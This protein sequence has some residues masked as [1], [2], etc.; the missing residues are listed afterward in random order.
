MRKIIPFLI[1][2]VTCSLAYPLCNSFAQG[3][4][5]TYQGRLNDASNPAQGF[6][7]LRFTVF[8]SSAGGS[9]VAGPQTNSA[10]TI[11]NGLFTVALNFGGGVFNGDSRWLE[12][13][14]RTN[15]TGAFT[16]LNQR[17]AMTAAPYAITATEATSGNIA[18]LSVSNTTVAATGVPIVTSGFITGATVTRGGSGYLTPPTVTVNDATGSGAVI[19]AAISDG[20]V[21]SLT[22]NSAGNG[23]YTSNATLTIGAPPSNAY[24]V[25]A[26]TNYFPGVN[27]LTNPNNVFAGNGAGLTNLSAWRLTGNAGTTPG[28]NFIGTTDNQ[29]LEFQANGQRILRLEPTANISPNV[30]GGI[31]FNGVDPGVVGATIGGGGTIVGPGLGPNRIGENLATIGGGSQNTNNGRF[32]TI[33]GGGANKIRTDSFSFAT[34]GGGDGNDI[35]SGA[36]ESFIGGGGGNVIMTNALA[37]VIGGGTANTVGVNADYGI[38]VG[39]QGNTMG[40]NAFYCTIGGGQNNAVA[41]NSTAA[42]IPGGQNNAATNYAF[43]AGRRAKANHDGTFVWADSQNADF[44]SSGPNQFLIRAA[45][46]VVINGTNPATALHVRDT[47]DTEVSIESTDAGG[48]RWTLQ[49]SRVTGTA[50]DA[51]FQIVDRTVGSSR[52]FIGTNGFVGIGTSGPTNRLHV[53]G[54]V[55]ATVFVTTSDRNAKQNFAPVSPTQVLEKVTSLP[56]QTWSFKEMPNVPHMGPTA[57]DFHAAFGLGGSDTTIATVDPDGVA[58]AAIQGLNELLKQKDRKIS[59]LEERL[60]KLEKAVSALSDAGADRVLSD[61]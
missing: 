30:I 24:Q 11:S 8:D 56:I 35:R 47:S 4:A 59:Q 9:A 57:Q 44:A 48:H 39:G 54:G 10:V 34:I 2:I 42:M 45:S 25:F 58:L 31:A 3:T 13:A 26:S 41:A 23:L 60:G 36:Q 29:P 21:I 51:S 6:Y 32:A 1:T 7:D 12:I 18:R 55:S 5:F 16:T 27:T 17:Q 20:A 50:T 15:N 28:V 49:S 40:T 33:G 19:I 38:I 22:V 43:A 37:A 14:V 61:N 52:M 53:S 46:G